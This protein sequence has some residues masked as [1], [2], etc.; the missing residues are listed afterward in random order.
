MPL[1]SMVL[2]NFNFFPKQYSVVLTVVIN[3]WIPGNQSIGNPSIWRFKDEYNET[4][5]GIA[6]SPRGIKI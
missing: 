2:S 1:F 5:K 3:Y 4:Q 6:V